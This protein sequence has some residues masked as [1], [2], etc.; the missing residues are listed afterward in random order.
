M[1]MQHPKYR[2]T[3]WMS[4]HHIRYQKFHPQFDIRVNDY[5]RKGSKKNTKQDLRNTRSDWS[6]YEVYQYYY[7]KP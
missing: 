1:R 7:Q 2:G 4:I 6:P 3:K 5:T